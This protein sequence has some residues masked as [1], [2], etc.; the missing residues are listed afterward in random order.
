MG[1]KRHRSEMTV[2]VVS[3]ADLNDI[4]LGRLEAKQQKTHR[5][6]RSSN[7]LHSDEAP[8]QPDHRLRKRSYPTSPQQP[9]KNSDK[10]STTETSGKDDLSQL[11][12]VQDVE[13]RKKEQQVLRKQLASTI[14]STEGIQVVSDAEVPMTEV[15]NLSCEAQS[16]SDDKAGSG[17]G[18]D[19]SPNGNGLRKKHRRRYKAGQH[20]QQ[21]TKTWK[22]Y[23]E[24]SWEERKA[25]DDEE[26]VRA[27]AKRERRMAS[28]QAMAPYNTTQFLMDQH[29]VS[30]DGKS[31][32]RQRRISES[33][34]IDEEDGMTS[35]DNYSSVGMA[36]VGEDD[37][38]FLQKEF[39]NAYENFKVERLQNMTKEDLIKDFVEM[40]TRLDE[41]YSRLTESFLNMTKAAIKECKDPIKLVQDEMDKLKNENTKLS[42]EIGL[43]K[44]QCTCKKDTGGAT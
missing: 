12:K 26:E 15:N 18:K 8:V 23:N 21:K 13:R 3:K 20:H 17:D 36:G 6:R 35:E 14:H 1:K 4:N 39:A 33:L 11:T 37:D 19:I 24:L 27:T 28:G 42:K 40:E 5:L 2:E 10:S 34:T 7:R 44:K 22:P 32:E 38:I 9:V 29:D 16:D 43:L 25:R 31:S 41:M 30:E